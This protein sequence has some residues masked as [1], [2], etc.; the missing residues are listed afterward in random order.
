M[1]TYTDTTKLYD[2]IFFSFFSSIVLQ[3][4]SL[5]VCL[6]SYLVPSLLHEV[7]AQP[8]QANGWSGIL[9]TPKEKQVST[10]LLVQVR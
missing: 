6:H 2:I 4:S 8:Q 10:S 3:Q 9:F 1:K 7:V 5:L